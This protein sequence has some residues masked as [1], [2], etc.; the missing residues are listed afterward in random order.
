M[1]TPREEA[2]AFRIWAVGQ[3][4]KWDCTLQEIAEETGLNV[5]IVRRLCR[6][7][8]WETN[9]SGDDSISV[10]SKRSGVDRLMAS[11]KHRQYEAKT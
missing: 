10:F 8:G 5:A 1:L 7:K 11:P 2:R 9:M 4:V 6:V 3:S